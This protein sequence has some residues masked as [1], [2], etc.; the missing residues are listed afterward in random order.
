M[1]QVVKHHFLAKRAENQQRIKERL[2]SGPRRTGTGPDLLVS[3]S[4]SR[5]I[6]LTDISLLQRDEQR[7]QGNGEYD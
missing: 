1:D 2:Q 4:L 7:D 5:Y 6:C 3:S